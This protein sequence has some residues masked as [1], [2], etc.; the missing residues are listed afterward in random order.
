MALEF[1]RK[2]ASQITKGYKHSVV[3]F[4][5]DDNSYDIRLFNDFIRNVKKAGIWAVGLVGSAPVESPIVK[6]NTVKGWHVKWNPRRKFAT[7]MAG[8]AVSIDLILTYA[9]FRCFYFFIVRR[10]NLVPIVNEVLVPPK[11]AS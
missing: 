2:N 9:S 11:L 1:L 8:F 6:N 5:D 7:D 4:A 10:Q 3:Y